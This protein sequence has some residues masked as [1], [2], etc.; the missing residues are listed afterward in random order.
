MRW[1]YRQIRKNSWDTAFHRGWRAWLSLVSVCFLFSFIGASNASQASFVDLADQLLGSGDQMLPGN[2]QYLKDYIASAP[3][4]QDVPFI[5][6]DFALNLIDSLS[7]S[8]TWVVRLSALNLAYFQRNPGEVIA[9]MIAAA[10]LAA[11]LHFFV[12]NVLIIGF[13]RYVME[14]CFQEKVSVLRIFAPFH[15]EHLGNLIWVM[16]RLHLALLLW[17]PTVIGVFY[18]A[19]QYSMVPYILAENPAATWKESK[20]LSASMT[21]GRKWSMF[22]TWLSYFYIWILKAVPLAGLCAAV[23][24]E[25]ELGAELYFTL[26]GNPAIDRGLLVE[27][28]FAGPPVVRA[29]GAAV[30]EYLLKDLNLEPP[31][32]GAGRLPYR[33]TDIVFIFFAF[34]LVGWIWEVGLLLV[35]EGVL[36]NRGT[37]YGPWIP[38]YGVGGVLIILLLDRFK[39]RKGRFFVMAVGLCALVEYLAS[40]LLDFLFNL[41]YWDYTSMFL[42]VNGRIC[43]AGLLAFGIVGLFG[44][45]VAAPGIARLADRCPRKVR[46][47][48]AAALVAAFLLDLACCLLFGFNSGSGVGGAI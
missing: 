33:F 30:P 27:S 21:K 15:R 22:C 37:M 12:Q 20:A 3:I 48:A 9:N 11:F 28:A 34:C 4:V 10:L 7:K 2:I 14:T 46:T 42:N 16:L 45:Y 5:T 1:N 38:I 35:Q 41:S 13:N 25:A 39:A 8:A 19:Y 47:A 26:R 32:R 40:F 6:S 31:R 29:R 43:L 18:K 36:V 24:L 44:V 17:L 23:P